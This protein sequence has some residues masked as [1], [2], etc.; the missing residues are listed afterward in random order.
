MELRILFFLNNVKIKKYKSLK[1]HLQNN[2]KALINFNALTI[3]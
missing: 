3:Y 1:I 2:N